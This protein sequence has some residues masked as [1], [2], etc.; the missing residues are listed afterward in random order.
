MGRFLFL[1]A[2]IMILFAANLFFGAV[3]IPAS[4]VLGVLT[5]GEVDNEAMR[6][7]IVG[8]RLPQAVTALLAGGGLGISGLM[9]QTSFRNPLAGPSILGISSGASLGVAIVMLFFG[10]AVS[11]GEL[12]AAGHVGTIAGALAGSLAVMGLL[13]AMSSVLKN[14]L[15]LLIAGIMTGYLTGSAVTLLSSFATAQGLQG[16]IMWG[17]GTFDN[18]PSSQLPWFAGFVGIG[19]IMSLS[20]AKPLNVMLLGES[21]ARN[22]GVRV[23]R[24]RNM[25]L[26]STG[27][28]TAVIT[29]Y[30]GPISF[31]GMAIPH[32]ARFYFRTDNHWVLMPATVLLG[33]MT[34]LACNA[35]STIPDNTVIPVNALTAIIGVPVVLTVIFR[36]RKRQA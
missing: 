25:L 11:I 20:L 26:L 23:T 13:I 36:N 30:C 34:A 9:L 16:Y 15:M 29:A 10:G 31:I 5:G 4:D 22:L 14:D 18:V 24:M 6:F 19:L 17:M 27:I 35:A 3:H 32:V 28:L 8:H 7:I 2:G 33:G 21:Y 1:T 12:S